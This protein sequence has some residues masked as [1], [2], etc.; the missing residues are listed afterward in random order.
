MDDES[1]FHVNFSP[2]NVVDD[3]L[4]SFWSSA[5]TPQPHWVQVQFTHRIEVS[6]VVVQTRRLNGI[7]IASATVGTSAGG[8]AL[9]VQGTVSGNG[10]ADIPFTFAAPVSLDTVRVTVNAETFEGSPRIEADVAEIRF[11][12]R[13][14]HLIG[15]P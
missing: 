11:Y 8:G 9:Q 10:S 7:V 6:R 13:G 14:G 12:D 1:A 5:E 3:N 15:N 4:S 2:Y